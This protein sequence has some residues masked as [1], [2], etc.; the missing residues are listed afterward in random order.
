MRK[1][2]SQLVWWLRYRL[3]KP[4]LLWQDVWWGFL[5]RTFK[6]FN[7]IEIRTLEPGYYDL[8]DRL[9]HGSMQL[10]VDFVEKQKP[11]DHIDWE[12]DERHSHAAKEVKALYHWWTV[13]RPARKSCVEQ[14]GDTEVPEPFECWSKK[15]DGGLECGPKEF[16][17]TALLYPK[18]EA[19][20]KLDR[21]NEEKWAQEE[22]D[23]LIRLAKIR[24]YLWT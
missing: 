10:L 17:L 20:C 9:L 2:Q 6:R 4:S 14:L 12:S 8:E 11:F 1:R 23:A 5:H 15:S 21:D 7:K 19:A 24:R 3:L 22:E 13:E 16:R 18:Y